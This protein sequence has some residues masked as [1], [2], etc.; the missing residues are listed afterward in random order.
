M[1]G[2]TAVHG[3]LSSCSGRFGVTFKLQHGTRCSSSVV[4]KPPLELW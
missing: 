4:V 3:C 1:A 2:D